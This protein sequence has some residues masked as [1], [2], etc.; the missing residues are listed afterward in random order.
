MKLEEMGEKFGGSCAPKLRFVEESLVALSKPPRGPTAFDAESLKGFCD[1]TRNIPDDEFRLFDC[2]QPDRLNMH[3]NRFKMCGVSAGR[4][5]ESGS[6][7]GFESGSGSNVAPFERGFE[8]GFESGS[9]FLDPVDLW[10]NGVEKHVNLP[11]QNEGTVQ[12]EAEIE[13]IWNTAN[14]IHRD[15]NGVGTFLLFPVFIVL[16]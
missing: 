15:V 5:S 6:A 12:I 4:G 8:P 3:K 1:C 16:A 2:N 13:K 11:T 9:G 14:E 7:R 10:R